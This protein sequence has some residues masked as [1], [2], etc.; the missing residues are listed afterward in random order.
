MQR[1]VDFVKNDH[2]LDE[3]LMQLIPLDATAI[4]ATKGGGASRREIFHCR[5]T[6]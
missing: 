1:F 3:G 5:H 6:T 2:I 4:R